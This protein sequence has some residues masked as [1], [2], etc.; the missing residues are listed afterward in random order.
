MIALA[1]IFIFAAVITIV[2]PLYLRFEKTSAEMSTRVA[3]VLGGEGH[4]SLREEELRQPLYYRFVRPLLSR[5]GSAGK[6]YMPAGRNKA[7]ETKL[8]VA[9]NPGGLNAVEFTMVKYL[10]GAFGGAIGLLLGWA[11]KMSSL[12]IL[13][14]FSFLGI[15]G[16]MLPDFYVKQRV[17][18]R[19]KSVRD[20]LP[21]TLDL[22]TVSIEAG[23]GLDGA[24]LKV[25]EKTK[26]VLSDEFRRVL[27]EVKVGKPRRE[28][29]RAMAIRLDLDDLSTFIG[30]VLMAEQMGVQLSNVMKLQSQEMRTRRRQRAQEAAMKAPVKMLFPLVMFIFPATFIILLGPAVIK[31]AKVFGGGG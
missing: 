12:N 22:L 8:L 19:Q 27:Q 29:L 11:A 25:V 20:A 1:V 17:Q 10:A 14:I 18:A 2:L 15:L 24:I 4:A 9:G 31:L 6:H 13:L 28:A 30:A 23:L 16:L 3:T 26:G 5:L 21:D 7:L